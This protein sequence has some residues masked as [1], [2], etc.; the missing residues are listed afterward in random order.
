LSNPDLGSLVYTVEDHGDCRFSVATNKW[1]KCNEEF[2]LGST[3]K[4]YAI[5]NNGDKCYYSDSCEIIDVKYMAIYNIKECIKSCAKINDELKGN[6]IQ[7]G[8]YCFYSENPMESIP[9][10]LGST[11]VYEIIPN[12]GYYILKCNKAEYDKLIDGLTFT[13]CVEGDNC[14]D[15]NLYDYEQHKC[16]SETCQSIG[17]KSIEIDG[18]KTQCVSECI[19]G[20]YFYEDGNQCLDSCPEGKYYYD[21]NIYLFY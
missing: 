16:L 17:K 3:K 4:Y 19:H 10:D 21:H 2:S 11:D 7:Y 14:P 5:S 9:S 12:N 20:T 13:M 1:Y 8:S 18:H 6:F 15:G